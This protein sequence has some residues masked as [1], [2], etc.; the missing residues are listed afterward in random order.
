MKN[1]INGFKPL[2]LRGKNYFFLFLILVPILIVFSFFIGCTTKTDNDNDLIINDYSDIYYISKDSTT[3][4]VQFAFSNTINKLE[5]FD[6]KTSNDINITWDFIEEQNS[7]GT[8]LKIGSYYIYGIIF[9][10]KS[11]DNFIFQ[12]FSLKINDNYVKIIDL[13]IEVK[14]IEIN[15]EDY[16][17]PLSTP[18]ISDFIDEAEWV[19]LPMDNIEITSINVISCLPVE[20]EVFFNSVKYTGDKVVEK[21][22]KFYI[23]VLFSNYK[24]SCMVDKIYI[25]INYKK[26]GQDYIYISDYS[27]FGNQLELLSNKILNR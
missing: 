15:N 14:R 17:R 7:D 12:S 21:L 13:N 24:S 27:I 10:L 23:K 19:F 16:I 26:N 25:Q 3:F 2:I 4:P 8:S 9:N 6:I 18:Y 20:N 11:D 1:S 22:D 5:I